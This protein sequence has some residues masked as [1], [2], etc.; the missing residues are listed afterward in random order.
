MTSR[1]GAKTIAI[2]TIDDAIELVFAPVDKSNNERRYILHPADNAPD[3]LD[4]MARFEMFS[5][6]TDC[7]I[8]DPVGKW[9]AVFN[10]DVVYD[11]PFAVIRAQSAPDKD[12]RY[13]NNGTLIDTDNVRVIELT[14]LSV[15]CAR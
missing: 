5:R 9:Y 1:T 2:G 12:R 8:D 14:L 6:T 3:Y 11:P 10:V 15:E 13:N 4:L 7:F